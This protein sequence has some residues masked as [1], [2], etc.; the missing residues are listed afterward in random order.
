[1]TIRLFLGQLFLLRQ[2]KALVRVAYL[3]TASFTLLNPPWYEPGTR[4]RAGTPLGFHPVWQYANL[5]APAHPAYGVM[6]IEQLA[7]LV[8]FAAAY[9]LILVLYDVLA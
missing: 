9:K 8:G 7:I 3:G 5:G 4:W 6:A 1:M 2:I